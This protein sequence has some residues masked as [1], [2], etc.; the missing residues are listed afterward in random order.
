MLW[1]LPK[2]TMIAARDMIRSESTSISAF[3]LSDPEPVES[4]DQVYGTF[5]SVRLRDAIL[6]SASA[7]TIFPPHGR[8]VDGGVGNF[9]NPC[10]QAAIEALG[11][12]APSEWELWERLHPGESPPP[13]MNTWQREV[14][15]YQSGRVI[16]RSFGTGHEKG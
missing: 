11:Y 15:R 3:R 8:F 1:Q 2:D 16:V 6:A 10:L 14:R 12:S 4:A 13:D 7:P 5:K 9:N